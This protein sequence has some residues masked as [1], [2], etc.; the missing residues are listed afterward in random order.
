M[1]ER[2]NQS[3]RYV[4]GEGTGR[5]VKKCTVKN[6]HT[7]W[8]HLTLYSCTHFQTQYIC[9]CSP[10]CQMREKDIIEDNF[11]SVC[12]SDARAMFMSGDTRKT[13]IKV[14]EAGVCPSDRWPLLNRAAGL[15]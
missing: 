3:D 14:R 13:N 15:F 7:I 9:R 1:K 2:E 6:S 4:R 11:L 12:V 5:E 8:V 10:W